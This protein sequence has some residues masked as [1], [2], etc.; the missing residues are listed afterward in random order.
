MNEGRKGCT[1][2]KGSKGQKREI[3]REREKERDMTRE[4]TDGNVQEP[5]STNFSLRFMQKGRIQRM[6]S[7]FISRITVF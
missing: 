4:R 2:A 7:C 1:F 3:E 6:L 5:Y